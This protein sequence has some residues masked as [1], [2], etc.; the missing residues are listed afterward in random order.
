MAEAVRAGWP[1]E[2]VYAEGDVPGSI[3]VR[4]GVL[5][6]VMDVETARP[7]LAVAERRVLSAVPVDATFVVVADRIADPGNLG[8][9]LRT[10]EASGAQAVVCT[11]GTVDAFS[12]KVVRSSAGAIFH[13]LVVE[14][15]LADVGLRRVGTS[16][17]HGVPFREADLS[18][19]LALVFGNEA[20][21]LPDN[22]P[23]D[24]WVT[25]PHAGRS[26]SLNVAM[27]AAIL[28]FAV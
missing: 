4:V 3:V 21:G 13:V 16:S 24:T 12:P 1:I 8:T 2:A 9:I 6:K 11:P 7:V 15:V 22:A 14:C 19:P 10:A 25:I 5:A 26:E 18:R 17:R 20:H 28:C 23:V 27:A